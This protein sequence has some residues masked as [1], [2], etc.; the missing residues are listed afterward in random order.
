MRHHLRGFTL[1]EIAI[2]AIILGIIALKL[3]PKLDNVQRDARIATLEGAKG[4][5]DS[6]FDLFATK[7]KTEQTLAPCTL[8]FQSEMRCLTVNGVEIGITA[9]DHPAILSTV[10]HNGITQLLAIT[11][12]DLNEA[13]HRTEKYQNKL[14]YEDEAEHFRAQAFWILPPTQEGWIHARDSRCKLIYLPL[15]NPNNH[16]GKSHFELITDGC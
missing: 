6:A 14:N 2:I 11:S 16:Q 7:V 9:D 3:L 4:A 1:I 13:D 10:Q 12:I 8:P 5:L 15:G